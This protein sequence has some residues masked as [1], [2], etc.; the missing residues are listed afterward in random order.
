MGNPA[1]RHTNSIRV[2]P[3]MTHHFC[4]FSL[5]F[6][7]SSDLIFF[8]SFSSCTPLL[9]PLMF[10][11][12]IQIVEYFCQKE[13]FGYFDPSLILISDFDTIQGDSKVALFLLRCYRGSQFSKAIRH[14]NE[15]NNFETRLAQVEKWGFWAIVTKLSASLA[16]SKIR[17][18][19]REVIVH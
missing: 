2:S 17:L 7:F 13:T 8:S 19:T 10:L 4:V 14:W 1:R 9:T 6:L 11:Y 12:G 16:P 5:R 3:I 18:F 15:N